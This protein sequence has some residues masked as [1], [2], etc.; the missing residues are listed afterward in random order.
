MAAN[1]QGV[2]VVELRTV[3]V[4]QKTK[5]TNKQSSN[6]QL[7]GDGFNGCTTVKTVKVDSTSRKLLCHP[8]HDPKIGLRLKIVKNLSGP[9]PP[10]PYLGSSTCYA[11]SCYHCLVN[12]K[13]ILVLP[14][15]SFYV[16]YCSLPCIFG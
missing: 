14:D 3:L 9:Y 15:C 7:E 4:Q 16:K 2:A 11:Y 1:K 10:P 6:M 13:Q 5:V 8:I 12:V